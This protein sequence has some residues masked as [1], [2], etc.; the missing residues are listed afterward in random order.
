[1]KRI[2]DIAMTEPNQASTAS[3]NESVKLEKGVV[4]S[5]PSLE[6]PVVA[7]DDESHYITGTKL[8]LSTRAS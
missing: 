6:E 2:I 3:I 7:L 1:L 5:T 4:E 8:Y